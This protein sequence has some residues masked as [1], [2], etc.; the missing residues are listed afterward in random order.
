MLNILQFILNVCKE[1][2]ITD[3]ISAFPLLKSLNL[4]AERKDARQSA[5]EE[6]GGKNGGWKCSLQACQGSSAK[7]R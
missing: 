2:T 6:E 4:K 3:D 7:V 5:V 1:K